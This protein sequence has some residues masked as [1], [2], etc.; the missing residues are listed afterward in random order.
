MAKFRSKRLNGIIYS[1]T[2]LDDRVIT[3][4]QANRSYRVQVTY[5]CHCFTVERK[6][7]HTPDYLYVHG[8]E[9]R[10]FCPDR[11]TLS[12]RLPEF[13]E[14]LMGRSV[15]LAARGNFFIVRAHGGNYVVF[16]DV[17]SANNPSFDARMIVQ[18]AHLRDGFIQYAN[19]VKFES[20]V[21]ARALGTAI[22]AGPRQ[23]IVRR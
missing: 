7:H 16:L 4:T 3:V 6:S 15:Y 9:E 21:E 12:L 19:P 5:S 14:S 22:V 23:R 13:A 2:H 1:M 8:N 20:L 10:A 18:S 17:R 11:H